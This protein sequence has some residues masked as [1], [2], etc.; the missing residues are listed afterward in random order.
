LNQVQPGTWE[1]NR[2]SEV[3]T[4]CQNQLKYWRSIVKNCQK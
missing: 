1:H 3:L 4:D 2:I